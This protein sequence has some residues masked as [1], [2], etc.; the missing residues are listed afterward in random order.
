[1]FRL[2]FLIIKIFNFMKYSHTA[3]SVNNLEESRKFYESVFNFRFCLQ[4][5]KAELGCEFINLEDEGHNLI[6]LLK[7]KSPK[8]LDEDLMNFQKVGIKHLSFVVDNLE[9]TVQ[10]AVSLG[11]SI[12]WPIQNET[13]VKRLTFISDPNGIPLELMEIKG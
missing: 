2:R 12:I 11:S 7:H 10:K 3:I 13:T 1:M 5:E 6:E 9:E 4:G 8:P